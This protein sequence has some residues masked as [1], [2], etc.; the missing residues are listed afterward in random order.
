RGGYAEEGLEQIRAVLAT[1]SLRL[2]GGPLATL[3]SLLLRRA[4]LRLRGL[5]WRARPPAELRPRDL[6]TLD[7]QWAAARRLATDDSCRG[8]GGWRGDRYRADLVLLRSHV[9]GRH[10]RAHPSRAG[11][12]RRG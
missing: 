9:S 12:H 2:G 5:R 11:L 8:A 4:W 3:A 6:R 1:I 7:V 10:P